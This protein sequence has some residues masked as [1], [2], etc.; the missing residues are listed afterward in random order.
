MPGICR[1]L[2]SARRK[3]TSLV[4]VFPHIPVVGWHLRRDLRNLDKDQQAQA[5]IVRL[6]M[7]VLPPSLKGG[8]V[9]FRF[10]TP[11]KGHGSCQR[12]S[13]KG[14]QRA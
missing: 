7:S 14:G 10:H 3:K 6:Q 4:T 2:E 9:E 13:S 5:L 8:S 12:G 11:N 1:Y